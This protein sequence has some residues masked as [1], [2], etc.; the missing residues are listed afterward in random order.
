MPTEAATVITGI[1]LVFAV[2]GISLA[3]IDFHTRY[4]RAPDATYFDSQTK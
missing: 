1:V 4:F 3:W 2:F